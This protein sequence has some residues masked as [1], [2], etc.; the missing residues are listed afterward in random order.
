M[1]GEHLTATSWSNMIKPRTRFNS[2]TR[3]V[4]DEKTDGIVSLI[5]NLSKSRLRQ[6][7]L[8]L[9]QQGLTEETDKV[10]FVRGFIEEQGW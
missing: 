10:E 1:G 9:E 2:R 5:E 6:V 7:L 4:L 8:A 3:E